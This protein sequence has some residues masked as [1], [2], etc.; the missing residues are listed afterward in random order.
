MSMFFPFFL[1]PRFIFEYNSHLINRDFSFFVFFFKV[2]ISTGILVAILF[3]FFF[4]CLR[5]FFESPLHSS[6]SPSRITTIPD[7]SEIPYLILNIL[8]SYLF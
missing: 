4:C 2:L 8:T 6:S 5:L 3:F 7:T 1:C